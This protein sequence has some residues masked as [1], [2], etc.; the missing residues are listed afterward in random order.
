[1]DNLRILN[2]LLD[3]LQDNLKEHMMLKA[4]NDDKKEIIFYCD[5]LVIC[6]GTRDVLKTLI[7]SCAKKLS[8]DF[9]ETKLI[10]DFDAVYLKSGQIISYTIFDPYSIFNQTTASVAIITVIEEESAWWEL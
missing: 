3:F 7:K 4:K 2:L 1:M 10:E 9:S 5:P 6:H 8:L